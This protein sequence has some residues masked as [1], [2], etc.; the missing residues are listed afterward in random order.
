[1]NDALS[2][3]IEEN[4]RV[5]AERAAAYD[6]SGAPIAF[7]NLFLTLLAFAERLEAEGV[8]PLDLVVIE[9]TDAIV[10][11]LLK[12]ALMR[13]GAVALP[14]SRHDMEHTHKLPVAFRIHPAPQAA[15]TGKDIAFDGSWITS[16]RRV[17]PISGQGQIVRSTSGTTGIPKLRVLDEAALLARVNHGLNKRG[18][19]KGPAIVGYHPNSS[20][21]FNM[22]LRIL[23]SGQTQIFQQAT[24][25]ATL[26]EMDR[27]GVVAA[28][29]SP[30]NFNRLLETSKSTDKRPRCLELLVVGGGAVSVE[31]AI[32]AER[33]FGAILM[34][35]Y[36]SNETGSIASCRLAQSAG[37]PGVVGKLYDCFDIRFTGPDGSQRNPEKGGEMHIWVPPELRVVNY[38]SMTPVCNPEGWVATGDIGRILPDGQ[39][40]LTGRKSEFLNVGGT[41]RAPAFFEEI[42]SAHPLVKTAIAFR[43]PVENGMD[44]VG[45][46]IE[47]GHGFQLDEFGRFMVAR[48]GPTFPLHI[49]VVDSIPVNTAGKIDRGQLTNQFI[50]A[51]KVAANK[52]QHTLTRTEHDT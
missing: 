43:A 24:P 7:R 9:I 29:L 26:D 42:A 49:A 28:Y 12:L 23:T 47:P 6:V 5:Y 17:V 14:G 33:H 35:S 27:R 16:P 3:N 36:G 2:R 37:M 45:L 51:H 44:H 4:C 18:A 40:C 19:P 39:I 31:T 8:R 52:K 11:S 21:G 13:I 1:L 46:A 10:S 41:K 48:L 15:L 20:P 30:F 22:F 38:P 50:V 25:E 32:E 34:N